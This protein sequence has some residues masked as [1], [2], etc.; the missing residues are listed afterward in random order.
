MKIVERPGERSS[1]LGTRLFLIR[2]IIREKGKKV[3]RCG[4]IKVAPNDKAFGGPQQ[5]E[6]SDD[7]WKHNSASIDLEEVCVYDRVKIYRD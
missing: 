1:W 2:Q 3:S 4:I 5:R 6:N 7:N